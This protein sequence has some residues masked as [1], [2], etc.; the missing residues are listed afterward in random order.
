MNLRPLYRRKRVLPAAIRIGVVARLQFLRGRGRHRAAMAQP[1]LGDLLLLG[2]EHPLPFAALAWP[3]PAV[4]SVVSDV[5]ELPIVTSQSN[6][7]RFGRSR[8]TGLS[9]AAR[10]RIAVG[11]PVGFVVV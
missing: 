5:L 6:G 10:C 8:R 1:I 11:R 7:V 4:V 2:A 3:V 9:R